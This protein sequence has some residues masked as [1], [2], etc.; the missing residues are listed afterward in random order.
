MF[1]LGSKVFFYF[2]FFGIFFPFLSLLLGFALAAIA[3]SYLAWVTQACECQNF[4]LTPM[5]LEPTNLRVGIIKCVTTSFIASVKYCSV[6]LSS[7]VVLCLRPQVGS[8]S[9]KQP[10]FFF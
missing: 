8:T 5:R 2:L 1:I 7:L 4:F 6:L 10:S 9:E 3:G